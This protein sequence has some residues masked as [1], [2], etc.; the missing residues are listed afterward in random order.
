MTS[1][2]ASSAR[3]AA[4]PLTVSNRVVALLAVA[5][6]LN[7]ADRGSL[8]IVAPLLKDRLAIGDA[9]MG[10][11]LSAF[12]WAYAPA[13]PFAGWLVQRADVRWVLAGG[14]A[15]WAGATLLS[16]FAGSFAMLFGLR[17]LLGLGESV[18][19]PANACLLARHAPEH[20]RGRAN[21]VIAVG[22]S[23]GPSAGTLAGG[24]ILARWGW[25]AVFLSLGAISLLWLVPWLATPVEPADCGQNRKGPP[26]SYAELLR[27]PAL[28]GASIGMFCYS[29][30]L[31]L[32]L[33]WL[34]LFL[35][36]QQHRS[37]TEMAWIGMAIYAAQAL[38]SLVSGAV[39]D[40]LIRAGRSPTWVRKGCLLTGF[41][42]V[43]VAMLM[44][45]RTTG[46]ATLAWL[47]VSA[48]FSGLS[49]PM[50]FAVGQ[51][52]AGPNAGG[53]WMGIQNMV[54]NLS[55]IAAPTLAGLIMARTGSLAEAFQLSAA[56]AVLG[57][58]CWGLVIG[59]IA[60]TPWRQAA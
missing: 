9:R 2:A 58:A 47:A 16:A 40:R 6:F 33:T 30:P 17:L 48:V 60:P 51:T 52:L 15:V 38:A 45:S 43:G 55:G 25:Q 12:F 22:L 13:Q 44:A 37:L 1:L 19:F 35:V 59:R 53:R 41:V 27:A 21:A 50:V 46:E 57:M 36:K 5:M 29:F 34:P 42:G 11:L 32:L 4:S 31:Y 26:P 49:C 24:L 18:I 20:L 3:P 7:Y 23:I 10:V 28:W 54:G 39:S 56:L 8:S 14:L